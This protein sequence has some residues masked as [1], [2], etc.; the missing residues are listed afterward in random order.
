MLR[1][2]VQIWE[3]EGER[4]VPGYEAA[5]AVPSDKLTFVYE[6][7]LEVYGL[8][9]WNPGGD[10]L[11]ELVATI[12]SQHTSDVNSERA[13]QRLVWQLPSWEAVRD[14]PAHAVE[15]AIRPGGLAHVKAL[16]IQQVLRELTARLGG[17]PLSLGVLDAMA[18]EDAQAYLRS[19]PGV[20]RKT[21]A[22]VLL[23]AL[24]RPVFPVDTHVLRVSQRL[25]LIAPRT[26]ADAAHIQLGA[27]IPPAWRH[28]LHINL[29][30]HGR[31]VCHAQR[32]ACAQCPV[33][34]VCDYYWRAVRDSV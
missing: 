2:A 19:L 5:Q 11:G 26:S 9:A 16:R 15:E 21:A 29:I 10:A 27:A 30:R 34:A 12:L 22:C 13:Y 4:T 24:G 8:P 31:Q 25:G 33:R 3:R 18:D 1:A 20:G 17:A 28:T 14:A 7:L 6:R 32:P 23:F